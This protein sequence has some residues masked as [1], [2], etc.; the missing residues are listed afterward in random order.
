MNLAE[1]YRP[2]RWSDVVGQDKLVANL[3]AMR[4]RTG[5]GGHA[6]WIAGP[7]GCGKSTIAKL[8][9]EE[10]ADPL[11]IEEYDAGELTAG[12]VR[13]L[14]RRLQV[15]GI[16]KGGRAVIANEAHGLRRDVIRALLVALEP[17]PPHVVWVFTTTV[18][19]QEKLF[20][21]YDD[22]S[23]LLSRCSVHPLS[24]RDLC[25]PFAARCRQI[26]QAEGLDGKPI[27]AYERL[28]KDLRNNLRAM[29]S[30]VEAGQMRD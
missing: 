7:S 8:I 22:S 4:D 13:E 24:R 3:L 18:E 10:I 5:F 9:A 23:P 2:A 15:R 12:L 11:C 29:L 6:Y 14:Q 21:D 26:A 28:A 16:G 27:E 25:K 1:K 19:G 20:E 30:A 17:I